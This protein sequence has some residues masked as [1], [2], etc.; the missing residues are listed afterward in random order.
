M[1]IDNI[2][3]NSMMSSNMVKELCV[4]SDTA[5]IIL[6]NAMEKLGLSARAYSKILK[7]ARTIA[8][9][10][11]S[12]NIKDEHIAEAIRYRNLDRNNWGN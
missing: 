1:N 10:E 5:N 8:D 7:V 12:M 9:L 3:T 6:Q 4:I 2:Y 11:E